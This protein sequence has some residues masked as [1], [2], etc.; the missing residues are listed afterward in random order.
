MIK[1]LIFDID[2][3]LIAGI[4]LDKTITH[5]LSSYGIYSEDN[6]QKFLN[7]IS[8]YENYHKE[9]E[10]I[11]YLQH[12]SQALGCKLDENFLKTHFRNLGIYAIPDDNQELIKT[13][14]QLSKKYEL[15]LLSNYFEESQRGRLK[16]I[17]IDKYFQECVMIG[18]HLE[19]DINGAKKCGLNTIWINS[20]NIVQNNIQTVAVDNISQ[21]NEKLIEC[22][23]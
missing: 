1:R 8:T 5:S 21:I 15:V 9:Y 2:G 16:N 14:D 19:L 23:E 18:D 10:P 17:G 13:I 4:N 20:K 11:Q 6:K 22:L 7:A 12:F 3:T